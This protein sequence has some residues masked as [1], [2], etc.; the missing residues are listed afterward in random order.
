MKE[1]G[2]LIGRFIHAV[3]DAAQIERPGPGK[4]GA[5]QRDLVADFPAELI[6]ELAADDATL[7]IEQERFLLLGAE[8]E[9]GIDVEIARSVDRELRKEIALA[10]V[11][12]AKPIRPR[13]RGNARYL[14]H[15]LL[16]GERQ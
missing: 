16:V 10:D 6:G 12:A 15:F 1:H 11:D 13:H 5:A 4:N 2:R 7:A 9:L 14:S 8:N 3:V